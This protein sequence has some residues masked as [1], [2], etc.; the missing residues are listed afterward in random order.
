MRS[1]NSRSMG[2][3]YGPSVRE[4]GASFFIAD[5]DGDNS[6]YGYGSGFLIGEE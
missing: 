2:L 6:D 1:L 3:K 5:G 4:I